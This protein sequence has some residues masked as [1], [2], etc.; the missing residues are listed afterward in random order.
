MLFL[1]SPIFDPY[2][3]ITLF[4]VSGWIKKQ[5]DFEFEVKMDEKLLKFSD[6]FYVTDNILH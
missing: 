3:N 5:T 2:N 1:Y 6:Q 4:M